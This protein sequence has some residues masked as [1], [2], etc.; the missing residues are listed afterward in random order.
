[1]LFYFTDFMITISLYCFVCVETYKLIY[2]VEITT[3]CW[4]FVVK[5]L[6]QLLLILY[7]HFQFASVKMIS[8]LYCIF[9][10]NN[11]CRYDQ[12]DYVKNLNNLNFDL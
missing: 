11:D 5:Y 1:M 10:I 9:A 6:F 2:V 8:A 12:S 4:D 7:S 3:T